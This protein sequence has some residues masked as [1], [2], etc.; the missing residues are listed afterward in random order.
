MV[1]NC[2]ICLETPPKRAFQYKKD[3][4]SNSLALGCDQV[5]KPKACWRG[6]K[7]AAL[8]AMELST[9]KQA[10]DLAQAKV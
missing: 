2:K 7:V 3:M 10:F 8:L 6:T 5:R 4:N 1:K 9:P